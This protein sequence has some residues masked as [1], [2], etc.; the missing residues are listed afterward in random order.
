MS[1]LKS[2]HN[3]EAGD[4]FH[5]RYTL[6]SR[7][8]V[9]GFAEVWKA[10]DTITKTVIALKIYT[11]L[12]NDGINDLAAEY[13][14][15]QAL[16]HTNILKADHFDR[17]GNIPYLVMKF[18][19]GGSLDKKLGQMSKDD[20]LHMIKD[21][22]AGLAYLHESKIVHQDIKPANV[23]ISEYN[24]KTSYLLS[25]FGIST[26]TKTRLSHSVNMLNRGLSMTE[27]Y[28][29]PEK[30][31]S[32]HA[33][34]EAN[35]HGDIFSLGIS[36][37]EIVT[38]H[39]PFDDL[40]TGR[41]LMYEN[42]E[43][44]FSEIS[45]PHIRHL[46]MECMRRQRDERPDADKLMAILNEPVDAEGNKVGFQGPVPPPI[47]QEPAAPAAA[48]PFGNLATAGGNGGHGGNGGN[49]SKATKRDYYPE[50]PGDNGQGRK[51]K[52]GLIVGIAVAAV[53]V[54]AAVIFMV[55][56]GSSEDQ[57]GNLTALEVDTFDI[58]G[59]VMFEMVKIPGGTFTLGAVEDD[60]KADS[61]E[62]PAKSRY[63][64][65][66]YIGR[67]EVTQKLWETIMGS[68]PSTV[69]G[70]S[71]PVNNVSYDDCLKF[72]Q[73]L[74]AKLGKQFALP[75]EA[76]W[77]YAAKGGV[78][79]EGKFNDVHTLYAGG[80]SNPG[81]YGWFKDN[82]DG[83]IHA[84]GEKKANGFGLY[85]MSGNVIEWCQDVYNNYADGKPLLGAD[86]RVLR[87]GWFDGTDVEV[88]STNRGSCQH[89]QAND[90]FGLRL[91]LAKK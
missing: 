2:I 46:V 17:W 59:D 36:I 90:A 89:D 52:T 19:S 21:V 25:D 71:L 30:F 63:M 18:C 32:K 5:N 56:W 24:G 7:I 72:I 58:N 43:V 34:R 54:I 69:K 65:E 45:D 87:G 91:V 68:N 37:Y 38:G 12:D 6:E 67:Y 51:S 55:P 9:G 83:K 44:D 33:D 62:R 85:D 42:V 23:L 26:K 28:A 22:S 40:S 57:E 75:T 86:E 27:A 35:N 66:F 20:L 15:M 31:S 78:D 73:K 53:A 13:T 64:E 16:S 50:I 77:E 70:D 41:Q 11:N 80:D 3:F 61:V 84:V 49:D 48:S 8:G 4:V 1:D 79:G 47:I 76:Q 81:D 14:Q 10:T 60:E 82:S 88:R 39:L 74:N 29:P